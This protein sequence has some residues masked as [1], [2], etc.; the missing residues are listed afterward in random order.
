GT[1]I[2]NDAVAKTATITHTPAAPFAAG[3]S[4]EAVL[5]FTDSQSPAIR[6]ARN[7]FYVTPVVASSARG[8]T[9]FIEAEDFNAFDGVTAGIFFDFGAPNG[10]Y[11]TRP[12]KHD[13]DYHLSGTNPDS[14]LYRV[15]NPP[16]GISVPGTPDNLR[17]GVSITPDYKIG[18][19]DTG[20][21]FNY[22]RTFP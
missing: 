12:A 10:S 3:S 11:D 7:V 17:A 18:W 6:T 8:T 22:T 9:L 1:T 5:T 13:V 14:P 20:D 16:N 2:V 4:H 21:W 19:N 15:L